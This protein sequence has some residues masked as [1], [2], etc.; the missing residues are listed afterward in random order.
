M[1]FWPRPEC[2]DIPNL[3]FNN[4]IFYKKR[5]ITIRGVNMVETFL[6]Q[7]RIIQTLDYSPV[8]SHKKFNG[9]VSWYCL[10]RSY[11]NRTAI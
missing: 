4:L 6:V 5:T 7:H 3:N 11:S 10:V 2:G 9:I 8:Y 1:S